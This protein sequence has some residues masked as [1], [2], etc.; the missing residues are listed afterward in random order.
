M[1][2][3]LV[4]EATPGAKVLAR[5]GAGT[6]LA[7]AGPPS[8]D[9][10]R[11]WLLAAVENQQLVE[12]LSQGDNVRRVTTAANHPVTVN[13]VYVTWKASAIG[14]PRDGPHIAVCYDVNKAFASSQLL[15]TRA[16]FLKRGLR[17]GALASR[18]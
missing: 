15:K 10:Q 13:G 3:L 8:F 5:G 11:V 16:C 4:A 9:A 7:Q 12:P 1:K 17:R 6:L 2:A 14:P 18:H